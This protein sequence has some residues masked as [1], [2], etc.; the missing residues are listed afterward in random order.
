MLG[1]DPALRETGYVVVEY[2]QRNTGKMSTPINILEKGIIKTFSS[3]SFA[4]RL[5]SLYE[6]V[7]SVFRKHRP[8]ALVLEKIYSHWKH[9]QTA[10]LL[11]HARAVVILCA[12]QNGIPLYEY[13][14]TH[15]K[16]ALTGRGNASRVQIRRMIE[17]FTSEKN[18]SVHIE[19][20]LSLVIAHIHTLRC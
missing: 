9:P 19:D 5:K 20:A 16:K 2:E 4:Q 14:S 7:Y 11:G 13:S 8:Q 12:S 15:I 18:L 1:V 10:S 3:Q 17:F 6:R